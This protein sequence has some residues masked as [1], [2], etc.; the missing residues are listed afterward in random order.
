MQE[1][2]DQP[3]ENET[4]VE[5]DWDSAVA[6]TLEQH[7]SESDG[8]SEEQLVAEEPE[9]QDEG[10]EPEQDS[11]T[12]QLEPL[13]QWTDEDKERFSTLDADTQKFLLDKHAEIEGGYT[14]KFQ[15]LSGERK[16]FESINQVLTP[17]EAVLKQQG[18][19]VAP[20][21]AQSLNLLSTLQRNPAEAVKRAIEAYRLTP[22][23]L[24]LAPDDDLTDPSIKAQNER[25]AT[26]ENRLSQQSQSQVIA[27]RN[28]G[29]QEIDKFETAVN[30]DGT[31]KHP[32]FDSVRTLMAPLVQQGKTL[33]EAY[34]AA[35]FTIP[36]YRESVTKESAERARKEAEEAADA[37]RKEKLAKAKKASGTLPPSDVGQENP[38]KPEHKSWEDSVRHTLTTLS[39]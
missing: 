38:G 28:Q 8:D 15:A 21:L 7:L 4:A 37:A 17:Y 36:E 29:Q 11:D 32:H 18:L 22:E 6:E 33:D 30:A 13:E 19:E 31:L 27:E 23:S 34:Q 25:I 24:G 1:S 35:V 26:L 10:S 20:V 39:T 2:N 14:A 9:P 12:E 3:G 16:R 5:T